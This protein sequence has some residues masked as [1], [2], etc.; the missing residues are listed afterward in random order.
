MARRSPRSVLKRARK[1]AMREKRELIQAKEDP[2]T[3]ERRDAASPPA[4]T[5][6]LLDA[7]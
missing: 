3:A 2:R 1:Q 7:E 4:E 5:D 6:T